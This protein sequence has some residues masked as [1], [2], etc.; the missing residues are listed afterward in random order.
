[1]S[2]NQSKYKAQGNGKSFRCF[3]KLEIGITAE[4]KVTNAV[5][6]W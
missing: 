6:S 2:G 1:M 4:A 3:W 5:V